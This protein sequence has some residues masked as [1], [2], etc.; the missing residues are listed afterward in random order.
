MESLLAALRAMGW[1]RGVRGGSQ[2]WTAIGLLAW[3]AHR[4]RRKRG[5]QPVWTSDLA[6]GEAVTITHHVP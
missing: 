2:V 4:A 1:R 6:P 3:L 5:P